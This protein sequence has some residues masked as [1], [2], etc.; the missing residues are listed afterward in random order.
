MSPLLLIGTTKGLVVAKIMDEQCTIA[1]IHFEGMP[2]SMVYVDE[3]I[4][5]WWV[6]LSH[7]HW[8]E[9][10]HYTNDEGKS[11]VECSVP[12]YAGF[13]YRPGKPAALKKIWTMKHAGVNRPGGLWL[14][15]EPGG[16]FYTDDNGKSFHLNEGLWNH[17]SRL[18]DTQWFGAG[19]DFPFLHSIIVNPNDSQHIYVGVS[20]AGVFE[21]KDGGLSWQARNTG[22]IAAYL[23][24]PKQE[25]GHDPHLIQM[26][27]K[28]PLIL[29]QQNHCGIF[30]T[31]DGAKT[32]IDV[33]GKSGFPKYGFCIAIDE[34]DPESA[35]VIPAQSDEKRIPVDLKLT[36]CATK[37]GGANW[38]STTNGLPGLSFELALRHCFVKKGSLLAFGTNNGNLYLS[39]DAGGSWRCNFSSL[40]GINALAVQ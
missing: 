7:R 10:L 28:N 16:L 11:W 2:V 3:R 31:V 9:K 25:V 35:W 8:G 26:S 14:G 18:D 6:A 32:W 29:W 1:S 23:P 37:D 38:H 27:N 21:T 30:R 4:N 39:F 36:V 20:C 19:K 12:S 15:T 34:D 22:L 13:S 17:P 24:N 5:T 33:S 40:A